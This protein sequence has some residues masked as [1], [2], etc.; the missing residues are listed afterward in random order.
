MDRRPFPRGRLAVLVASVL[1][2]LVTAA[3]GVP[4]ATA[5][6]ALAPSSAR[7]VAAAAVAPVWTHNPALPDGP[8]RW[9]TLTPDWVACGEGGQSPIVI[10]GG[11][12]AAL[13]PLVLD[14]PRVPLVVENTGHVIEVPQPADAVGTLRFGGTTYRLTQWHVHAPAEHVVNG[15][16]ADLEVHLVHQDARGG[17]AVLALFAD[18]VP[19]AR[20]ARGSRGIPAALLARTLGAAPE[21]AGEETHTGTTA[22][23][24]ALLPPGVRRSGVRRAVVSSYLTYAGSLTTPPCST[25]VRWFV[26]PTP[27]RVGAGTVARLHALVARFPGYDGYPD[28]NRPVQPLGDRV[29]QRR[30]Q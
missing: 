14:Y 18:V 27:V 20:D 2:A 10:N 8:S 30:Q 26:V 11:R 24:E 7:L 9:A 25:G 21:K 28:N 12:R 5:A 6:T 22:T 4:P 19:P 17:T 29:V 16:R 23:A 15:R 13:P 3:L 1:V